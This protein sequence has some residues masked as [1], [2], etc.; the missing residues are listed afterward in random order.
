MSVQIDCK[1]IPM[2]SKKLRHQNHRTE[3]VFKNRPGLKLLHC[4][5]H[6]EKE[7]KHIFLYMFA[8]QCQMSLSLVPLGISGT[9]PKLSSLFS[10]KVSMA[11]DRLRGDHPH[12]PYLSTHR[13]SLE[14]SLMG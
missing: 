2:V 10:K 4:V 7:P 1:I 14:L 11:F 3:T 13:S 12:C 8:E 5:K 9:D 6:E